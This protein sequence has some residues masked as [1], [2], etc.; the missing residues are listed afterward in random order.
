MGANPSEVALQLLGPGPWPLRAKLHLPADCGLLHPTSRSRDCVIQVTHALRFTMQLMRGDDSKVDPKTGKHKLFE[1][2]VR[3]PVNVLSVR[4]PS[5]FPI[6]PR[7]SH[8]RLTREPITCSA[9]R[10]RSIP[11]CHATLRRL[12]RAQCWHATRQSV[13]VLQSAN[14][15]STRLATGR[16]SKQ[17]AC[18]PHHLKRISASYSIGRLRTSDSCLDAKACWGMHLLRTNLGL[19]RRIQPP[20]LCDFIDPVIVLYRDHV[21]TLTYSTDHDV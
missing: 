10:A 5:L 9:M 21:V 2:S 1:I 3:T 11:L 7:S 12:M 19:R 6:F 18:L 20:Y 16:K 13:L 15:V 4:C 17:A 14:D 8:P